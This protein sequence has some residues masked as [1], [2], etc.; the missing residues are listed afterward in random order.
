M[1][2]VVYI[3]KEKI[4]VNIA[5]ETPHTFCYSTR[6]C[7]FKGGSRWVELMHKREGVPAYFFKGLAILET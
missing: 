6:I 2:R 5:A 1:E 4:A 7:P 3:T